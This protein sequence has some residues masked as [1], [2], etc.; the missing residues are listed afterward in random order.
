MI[1]VT[2]QIA[3]PIPIRVMSSFSLKNI[4]CKIIPKTKTIKKRNIVAKKIFVFS[5]FYLFAL[6]VLILLDNFFVNF[7][8]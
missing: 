1:A 4:L 3:V 8:G 6:F 2:P 5:I 7:Y